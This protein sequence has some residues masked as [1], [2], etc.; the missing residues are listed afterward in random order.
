[1]LSPGV[2]RTIVTEARA[3]LRLDQY[4]AETTDGLSRRSARRLV[5]LGGTHVD[6]RRMRRCGQ[7]LA[8]G[9]QVELYVDGLPPAPFAIT[10]ELILYEDRFL[11]ALNKPPGIVTQPT[12]AR[13]QGTLYAALQA[14]LGGPGRASLGMVQRLDRDTSGVIVFSIH[15]RAHKGLTAT[16]GEHRVTKRYLALVAGSPAAA[17]GEI[18]SLLARRRS[19]NRMISVARGGKEALTRYRVAAALDGASLVEVEIL[20]GRSHQIRVHFAEMGHPLLGDT[21]Y[22][23]PSRIGG[24]VVPRQMLHAAELRLG[25]PVDGTSLVLRAP[26]PDDFQAVLRRLA[27]EVPFNS[28]PGEPL[29][30]LIDGVNR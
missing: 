27:G 20:T 11:L 28:R 30:C 15:P 16:F 23:G 2:Y 24:A 9:Q 26:L 8:V 19:T 22:G 10:P 13:Y 1:M 25:H 6:G 12:P 29:P 4:L 17:E 18:C 3:G 7:V 5:E 21:A 14:H